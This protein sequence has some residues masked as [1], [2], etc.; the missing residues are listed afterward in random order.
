MLAAGGMIE[1]AQG[2]V[3]LM[4]LISRFATQPPSKPQQQ[5]PGPSP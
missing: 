3:D 2:S 5:G 1:N 4:G